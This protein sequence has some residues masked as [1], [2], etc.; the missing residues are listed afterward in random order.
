MNWIMVYVVA[1]NIVVC[2]LYLCGKR[3]TCMGGV[4]THNAQSGEDLPYD[5]MLIVY[6]TV[7]V[8]STVNKTYSLN[9]QSWLFNPSCF[10]RLPSS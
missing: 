10:I 9:A 2:I 7:C 4:P 8:Q 1:E 6:L 5:I 3:K